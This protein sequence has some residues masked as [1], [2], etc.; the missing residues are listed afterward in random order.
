MLSNK[1]NP[2]RYMI[3]NGSKNNKNTDPDTDTNTEV[4][5][6]HF[7]SYHSNVCKDKKCFIKNMIL[8]D[9]YYH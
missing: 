9:T 6:I 3:I 7:F 2:S 4:G 1:S 8:I 5:K